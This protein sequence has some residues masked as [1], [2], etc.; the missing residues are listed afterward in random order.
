M[1]DEKLEVE[2]A[3]VP[4]MRTLKCERGH[5]WHTYKEDW[6]FLEFKDADGQYVIHLRSC[7]ICFV[8]YIKK[9]VNDLDIAV[10]S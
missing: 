7:P 8:Q 10:K 9:N 4:K 2:K 3:K 5:Q 1:P 6:Y